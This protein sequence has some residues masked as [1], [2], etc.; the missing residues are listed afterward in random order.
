M[1][2]AI[3][4]GLFDAST[5]KRKELEII[6]TLNWKLI[7]VTPMQFIEYIDTLLR[8]SFKS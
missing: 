6:E 2:V 3:G 1:K 4:H 5:M 8:N 7:M